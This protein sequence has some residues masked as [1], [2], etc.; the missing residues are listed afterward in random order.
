MM[1]SLKAWLKQR[2]SG[3]DTTPP[4]SLQKTGSYRQR[5]VETNKHSA[6]AET[7]VQAPPAGEEK[8]YAPARIESLGP[9]KNVYVRNPY[10]REELGTHESL[11]IVDESLVDGEEP[12]GIDPYNTG[13]FDKSR[14]WD[15]RFRK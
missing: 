13:R 1:K 8:H 14:K 15:Q 12:D 7:P 4:P 6:P 3:A 2:F 11:K 9:G 10:V 5:L